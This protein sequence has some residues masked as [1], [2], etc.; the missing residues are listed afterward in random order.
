MN[1]ER[2]RAA[3]LGAQ[4]LRAIYQRSQINFLPPRK[5]RNLLALDTRTILIDKILPVV[6]DN[7][8]FSFLGQPSARIDEIIDA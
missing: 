6:P 5:A 3:M 1:D 4:M 7:F 2:R 8:K